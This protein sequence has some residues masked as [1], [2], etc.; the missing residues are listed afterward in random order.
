MNEAVRQALERQQELRDTAQAENRDLTDAEMREFNMLQGIIDALNAEEN[1]SNTTRSEGE[2]EHSEENGGN[3]PENTGSGA[4]G[5]SSGVTYT[6]EQTVEITNM[7]RH[8]NVDAAQYLSRELSVEAIRREIIND[9]M[10]NGTPISSRV[11]VTSDEGDKFRAAAS[12]GILLRQGVNVANPSDGADTYRSLSARDIAIECMEREAPGQNYRHMSSDRIYEIAARSFYNPT[13]AFPSILDDVIQKAYI[14]GLQKNRT[15]YE[16]WV[17]F[18]SLSNFKK[19]NNH[20]YIMSLGGELKEIPENGE[21]PAYIPTD[22]KMPE[23]Q[24]KTYGRQFTM[25]RE[26]FINDDIGLLTTMPQRYAALSAN[27]QNKLVYQ[28][29]LS[30]KKIFDGDTLFSEKRKNTLINGTLP[31]MAALEKMIYL[32]GMQTD[33]T[34]DTLQLLPDLFIVPLGMGTPLKT[35]L[36]SPTINTPDNTQANNPYANMNFTV[37]EDVTLNSMTK[38]G[39]PIP[40][41]MGVNGEI[42]QIDY[43]NG[44]KE[45]NIRRSERP[46][47]LGFVWDVYHDFSVSVLHPQAIIRNPGVVIDMS[48]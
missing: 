36:Y 17:K 23:R 30:G 26:A 46:G 31:T 27:T 13:A 33:E 47:T 20:E 1:G 34:G 38:P 14:A 10:E 3:L 48:E 7:C 5:R 8:F 37:V 15:Q 24:L 2:G 28:L 43:L 40:W 21:L 6:P 32:L 39:D 9:L 11:T 25:T 29:L 18:G 41:F 45:A 22:A 16:K 44:Q 35:I 12:D 19:S 42:I 4:G